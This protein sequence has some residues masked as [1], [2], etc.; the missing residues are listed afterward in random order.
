[1]LRGSS[2]VLQAYTLGSCCITIYLQTQAGQAI[3]GRNHLVQAQWV[4][5]ESL[6]LSI[7]LPP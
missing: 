7:E 4:P 1:M 3:E 5:E 2:G 6:I